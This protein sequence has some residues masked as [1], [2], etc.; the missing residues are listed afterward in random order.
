MVTSECII[1]IKYEHIYT[2][3][4]IVIASSSSKEKGS[5]FNFDLAF[6]RK[7]QSLSHNYEIKDIICQVECAECDRNVFWRMVRKTRK[8]QETLLHLK[9]LKWFSGTSD[10]IHHS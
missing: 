6:G 3:S 10:S 4:G 1:G 7:L 8:V 5:L 2:K 9:K